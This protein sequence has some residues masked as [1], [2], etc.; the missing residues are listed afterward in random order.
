MKKDLFKIIATIAEISVEDIKNEEELLEDDLGMDS[1]MLLDLVT[2]IEKMID[3]KIKPEE[4]VLLKS[5][6]DVFDFIEER[7]K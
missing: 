6:K 2:E 5:V 1:L 7:T 4:M 3:Q